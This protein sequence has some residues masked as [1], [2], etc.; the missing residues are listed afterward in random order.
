MCIEY[1]VGTAAHSAKN[2]TKHF[3]FKEQLLGNK[4]LSPN[5]SL[6]MSR[7]AVLLVSLCASVC[8]RVEAGPPSLRLPPLPPDADV[9]A[10]RMRKALLPTSSSARQAAVVK[11]QQLSAALLPSNCTWPDVHYG[12]KSRTEWSPSTHVARVF[13]MAVGAT[14]APSGAVAA[15]LLANVTCA[16]RAW[17]SLDP[18]SDNWWFNQI[19][20]PQSL[21][22]TCLLLTRS[23]VPTDL[24]PPL[25]AIMKRA[26]WWKGWT[27]ANLVW[28]VNVQIR[29]GLFTGNSTAVSGGFQR[30]FQEAVVVR[31]PADGIQAD[32]SYSQHGD[33]GRTQLLAGSYGSV[34]TQDLLQAVT[35][36]VNTTY[37]AT[38][39]QAAALAGFITRGQAWMTTPTRR[40]D[41]NVIGRGATR[42]GSPGSV[43][44]S[45]LAQL[46]AEVPQPQRQ[47]LLDYAGRLAGRRSAP[48]L[49]GST[50]YPCTDYTVHRGTDWFVSIK[51][52]SNRTVPARCVNEEAKTSQLVSN[53]AV[54]VYS[55]SSTAPYDDMGGLWDYHR[56]PGIAAEQ[57]TPFL[58]CAWE[59]VCCVSGVVVW[60]VN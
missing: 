24:Q 38:A 31:F 42:P 49:T 1:T 25:V 52:F 15:R 55:N 21:S 46:A 3:I 19:D 18:R 58:A 32:G 43:G 36:S 34:F 53:G 45:G 57:N 35:F 37:A 17:V 2:S 54:A 39:A 33:N 50:V 48:A 22:D 23:G 29:R 59:Y 56:I 51:T 11:A 8:L 60:A 16:L 5:L 6:N 27:G 40:W 7:T 14:V 13:S 10:G 12:D 28:M 41:F 30:L 26:T 9:V 44:F 20:V 4:Y 47:Q